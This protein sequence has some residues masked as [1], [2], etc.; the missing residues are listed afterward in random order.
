[1]DLAIVEV[2]ETVVYN[3]KDNSKICD[4]EIKYCIREIG[5]NEDVECFKTYS[6]ALAELDFIKKRLLGEGDDE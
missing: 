3:D 5:S 6:E 2:V 1:M 4:K